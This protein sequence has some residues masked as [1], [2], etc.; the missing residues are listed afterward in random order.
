M[1]T[2]PY[3]SRS[4]LVEELKENGHEVFLPIVDTIKGDSFVYISDA[5][6][7]NEEIVDKIIDQAFISE[8]KREDKDYE[9]LIIEG[10]TE[11]FGLLFSLKNTSCLGWVREII[12]SVE[13]LQTLPLS[14]LLLLTEGE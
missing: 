4:K 5:T 9:F 1:V 14:Y 8:E 11:N 12:I 13:E 7:E 10:K 2:I 3:L 6:K